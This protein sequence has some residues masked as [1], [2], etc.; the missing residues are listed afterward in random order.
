MFNC[1]EP[2]GLLDAL[3]SLL[4]K[5]KYRKPKKCKACKNIRIVGSS[6]ICPDCQLKELKKLLQRID[7]YEK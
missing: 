2:Y 4:P 6:G 7:D 5:D 1:L 3:A